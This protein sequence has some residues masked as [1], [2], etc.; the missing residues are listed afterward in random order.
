MGSPLSKYFRAVRL[1]VANIANSPELY[2]HRPG[3]DFTRHR[4]LPAERTV[5][6]VLSLLRQ[7]LSVEI[8]H[9]FQRLDS[10]QNM[11]TKSALVQ[12]RNKM[13]YAFFEDMFHLTSDLFYHCFEALRWKRLRLWATDGSGFRLPDT[14]EMGEEFGWHANQHSAVPSARILVHFDVLN[15]V[16]A[17]AFLHTRYEAESFVATW[18]VHAVPSDVLMIYDRGYPAQ[19]I[20]W[21]HRYFGSDCLV[22]L[23][24]THSNIV[25]EFVASKKRQIIVRETLNH[26][27][28]RMLRAL[29]IPFSTRETFE[30]RLVRVEL[31]TGETEVLLTTLTDQKKYPAR[32]FGPLYHRRWGV[33]TCFFSLKS[34]LQLARFSAV[35]V[36]NAW[37]DIYA[38]LIGY[39]FLSAIH[40]SMQDE[41]K[42]INTNRKT[43]CQPNRNVGIGIFKS[44]IVRLFLRPRENLETEVALLKRYLLKCLEPIKVKDRPREP[45]MMRLGE[46]HNWEGNYR[47]A[48]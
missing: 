37:Q 20:P 43:P 5:W 24:L 27:S 16:I 19:V 28:K 11:P 6:L 4:L 31:P 17:N 33:E 3:A 12:A 36:N 40:H 44:F 23:S 42:E 18:H 45:K 46:R 26:T 1:M 10:P 22:R 2:F 38:T 29:G 21:L 47:H 34:L 14:D 35:T 39:N 13:R 32:E 15:Q 25:K 8:G 7:S 9:F 48:L 41:V 30:Y